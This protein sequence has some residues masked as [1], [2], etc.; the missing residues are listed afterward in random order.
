MRSERIA[1][2]RRL[3]DEAENRIREIRR[4]GWPGG[5]LPASIREELSRLADFRARAAERIA[6][7]EREK[8]E[9]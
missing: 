5:R 3:R 4:G 8:G 1:R 6:A 2:L 9:T 7:I